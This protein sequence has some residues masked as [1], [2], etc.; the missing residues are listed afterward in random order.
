[1]HRNL[2]LFILITISF[3]ASCEEGFDLNTGITLSESNELYALELNVSNNI[4]DDFS[5]VF[6]NAKVKR[7]EEYNISSDSRILG[8][9]SLYSLT[10]DDTITSNVAQFPTDYLF[11]PIRYLIKLISVLLEVTISIAMEYGQL[12]KTQVQ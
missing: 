12:I 5:P 9:W 11:M 2:I 4:T 7:H 3:I 1:M 10:I 8:S 6:F